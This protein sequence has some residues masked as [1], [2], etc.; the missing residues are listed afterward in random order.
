MLAR[1]LLI[2]RLMLANGYEIV[3]TC[4]PLLYPCI[5]WFFL[6]LPLSVTGQQ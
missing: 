4:K 5:Y 3:C 2:F 6:T 1:C